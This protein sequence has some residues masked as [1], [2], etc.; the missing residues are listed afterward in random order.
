MERQL[1][2]GGI[3]VPGILVFPQRFTKKTIKA[4]VFT[5]DIG[6]TLVDLIWNKNPFQPVDG[7]SILQILEGKKTQRSESISFEM[8]EKH[9]VIM[10][11]TYK[12]HRFDENEVYVGSYNLANDFREENDLINTNPLIAEQ[13]M[14]KLKKW[15]ESCE[16]DLIRLREIDKLN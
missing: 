6:S 4:P 12:L 13:L 7:M 15:K 3:R 14:Q 11:D 10:D 8:G 9:Q 2:E 5:A 1:Y 16:I